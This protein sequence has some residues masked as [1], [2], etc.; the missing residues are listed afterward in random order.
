MTNPTNTD[1]DMT[2]D[3]QARTGKPP[4]PVKYGKLATAMKAAQKLGEPL[5][6][7]CGELPEFAIHECGTDAHEPNREP[8]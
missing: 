2:T 7:T 8:T 4:K 3:S 1:A 6:E 5:C